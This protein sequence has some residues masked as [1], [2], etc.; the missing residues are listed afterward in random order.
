MIKLINVNRVYAAR[1][2]AADGVIRALDAFS[3]TVAPGEWVSIMGPSGS[4]KS[5]LVT[6]I[7]SLDR[8][9]SG[10]I[11]LDGQNVANIYAAE[12]IRVLFD[13]IVFVFQQFHLIPFL[14]AL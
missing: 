4:G 9:S 14:T 2:E 12:L 7:G 11:C 10:E 8:P 3:L 5:T 1:A 13:N 6:H